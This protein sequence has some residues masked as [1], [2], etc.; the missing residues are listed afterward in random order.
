[1]QKSTFIR[2]AGAALV[3]GSLAACADPYGQYGIS[4]DVQRAAGGAVAGAVVA[5]AVDGNAATGALVGAAAGALCDDI[6][7]CQ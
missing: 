1:M 4:P 2:F 5:K 7:V 6:G 3:V